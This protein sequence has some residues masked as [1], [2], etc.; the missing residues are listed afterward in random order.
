MSD[1]F[2]GSGAFVGRDGPR[3]RI[4]ASFQDS[5]TGKARLVLV[6]GEA[7]I[8]K[9]AL[10][11]EAAR[12]AAGGDAR[13]IWGTC[14]DA[15]RAPGYWPWAQVLRQLVD[16]SEADIVDSTSDEDRADLARL[17]PLVGG[18]Q[19]TVEEPDSVRAQFR[20]FDAVARWLER[21]A[22]QQPLVVAFDDLQWADGSSLALLDFVVRAHRPVPLLLL[23]AYRHDELR[24]DVA[25]L[26]ADITLRADNIRLQGL[27]VAEV[28]E[29]LGRTGGGEVAERWG[30]DV[31]GRTAGHP[32]LVRELSHALATHEPV[33]VVPAAAHDLIAGRVGRLSS[34]CRRLL[35]AAA[36]GGSEVLP[37]VLGDVLDL[38]PSEV[39]SHLANAVRA[40]V[41]IGAGAGRA[42]F[43]HDLYRETIYADI[44]TERRL[45]LHREVGAALERRL[46]R[47]GAVFAGE[48]AR[49]FAAAAAV[50]GP[51]RAIH[52]ALEAAAADRARLAF[53]EAAAQLGRV[54]S[55][56]EGAGVAV[57]AGALVD[58]VVAQA[59]AESRAGKPDRARQLLREAH[60]HAARLDD[61]ERLSA[62][63][64]GLQ[65]LGARF[66]MPRDE[67]V[68]LLDEARLAVEG[69]APAVEAQVTASLAREL[70]HSVPKD[71]ARARPLSEHAVAI[72]RG[73]DDPATLVAC[74]LAR[75]DVL[76]TPGAAAE[77][78][79]VGREIVALAE[80]AGDD[81]R[82]SEGHLLT[83]N[84]LLETGSPAFRTDLD[85]FLRLEER[86]G[87]PRHDYFAL[88][89]RAAMA[90]LDGS[91]EEGERLVHEAAALGERIGEPDTG[92]VRMSQLLEVARAR[93]EPSQ[94]RA[95]AEM[96][97]AWWVGIPAHAHAVAA[98]LLA[99]AG[100]LDGARRA[101]DTVRELVTW[102]DDRSYLWSVFVGGL[103]TAAARL[104]DLD[105]SRELLT[106]LTPLAGECGVNGAVVCFMGSH[107]HWAGV[108]AKALGRTG[109]ARDLL[110]QA[111]RAH[112]RLGA[113]AWEAET[114]A[115]LGDLCDDATYRH[116]AAQL[117]AE[118]GLVGV[119]ARLGGHEAADAPGGNAAAAGAV[120]RHEGDVWSIEHCGRTARLRDAKGLHD[121]AALLARPG[122][123]I[124]VLD[125][126]GSAIR[127]SDSSVP[128]LDAR[129]RA[130]F[131]RRITDLDEDLAEAQA[132]HDLGWVERVES[133][134]EA[135]LDELRRA[136]GHAGKDRGLGPSTVERA[137]KAVT[138]RLRDTISRIEA[139]LPELGSHL[140]RSIVTGTYC[141][142]QPAEP[143]TW[144]LHGPYGT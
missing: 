44:P 27:S 86:L 25:G 29:L 72:A 83:A 3:A 51:D 62:V 105:L 19:A 22:R 79:D 30:E 56:L 70:Y 106:E 122:E 58:L 38:Q 138:A 32:F 17:V 114:C 97:V 55:A 111:L 46:E 87:Q 9:T 43:A 132:H 119:A 141:R 76:W 139:A 99:D 5:L 78:V 48:I 24:D 1:G 85:A 137:R 142:Y 6:S 118:L 14:W 90:L 143:L 84:A 64:L 89:R 101:L 73:L 10:L 133:E 11:T 80:R 104:G 130:E 126:A 96:A 36:V 135:L 60:A 35:Y 109:E 77:R 95:T 75:H 49:H 108:A 21:S 37:D 61:P 50:D 93:G 65:R 98:G 91:L 127:G 100:D 88:T 117:A 53:A 66:A 26:F 113:R 110:L 68:A 39:A 115:V 15:D 140:D 71:R 82:R 131:K 121:L 124:H 59:D 92:N 57:G 42:R 107:A 45:E 34:V 31:Y 12:E 102:R 23:G 2:E 125:L 63:A 8:G 20:L 67:V 81:E 69:R 4:R 74:L 134:R 16:R 103:T 54:R 33:D 123:D 18:A 28:R 52:W 94:L 120:C 7:G 41:L 40:G 13:T 47:G 116:R 144:N 128:V 136:T 129:A 112:E